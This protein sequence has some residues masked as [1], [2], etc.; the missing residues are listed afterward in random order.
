MSYVELIII[1]HL[2]CQVFRAILH[3]YRGSII[4]FQWVVPFSASWLA[5][6]RRSLVI[7]GRQTVY[8]LHAD[9]LPH[10]VFCTNSRKHITFLRFFCVVLILIFLFLPILTPPHSMNAPVTVDIAGE[11]DPLKIAQKELR[12]R[13]IPMIIRRYLP[14]NSYEDWSLDELIID[15]PTHSYQ[16]QL[17]TENKQKNSNNRNNILFIFEHFAIAIGV[18]GTPVVSICNLLHCFR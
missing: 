6:Q 10:E 7:D 2:W 15:W 1:A 11:T 12:E 14:D 4:L 13:K 16:Q 18:I 5:Q 8:S 9:P 17:Y 3:V